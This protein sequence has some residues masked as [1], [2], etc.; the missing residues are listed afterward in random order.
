MQSRVLL[1]YCSCQSGFVDPCQTSML[2][3]Y[4]EVPSKH[5]SWDLHPFLTNLQKKRLLQSCSIKSLLFGVVKSIR[6]PRV[7]II[8]DVFTI[9]VDWLPTFQQFMERTL[10]VLNKHSNGLES[11][12]NG[13]TQHDMTKIMPKKFCFSW[14]MIDLHYQCICRLCYQTHGQVAFYSVKHR[15]TVEHNNC[16]VIPKIA[17][18][19]IQFQLSYIE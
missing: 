17:K 16:C 11:A 1:T 9:P 18:N 14:K 6:N 12:N 4:S 10:N 15:W 5:C 3:C 2:F 13:K 19:N 8:L 7:Y